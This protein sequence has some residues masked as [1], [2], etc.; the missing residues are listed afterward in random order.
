MRAESLIT[1]AW[2][3]GVAAVITL[4][5]GMWWALFADRSRGE[6]RC[7]RCWHLI[8]PGAPMQC[9]ECGR[10]F[11]SERDLLRTRRRW[12]LATAC[13]AA[14]VTGT[15]WLRVQL[16]DSG[17]WRLMPARALIALV[18]WLGDTEDGSMARGHLRMLLL[19]EALSDENAVRLLAL[20][21][22][23]DAD[24]RPG[25]E[26]WRRRYAAWLDALR[27]PRFWK[28]YGSRAA[29]REAA[30]A[31]SPVVGLVAPAVWAAGAPLVAAAEIDDWFPERLGLSLEFV[32]APGL[33]LSADALADLIGR[34]WERPEGGG[35][36]SG[37]PVTLG[38]LPAGRHAGAL[39]MRWR[40][41]ESDAPERT[42]ADGELLAPLAVE[43]LDQP[44]PL[45]PLHDEFVDARVREVF[46]PGLIRED[47]PDT[48]RFAFSYRPLETAGASLRDIAFG[49]V[50]EA[51]ERGVPRRTLHLWWCGDQSSRIGFE[52]VHEEPERLAL[53]HESPDWTLRVR[54][55]ETLARRA[56]GL[57]RSSGPLRFWSGELTL[58]LSIERSGPGRLARRWR[59]VAP[60]ARTAAPSR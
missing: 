52:I 1:L 15:L 53:A 12:L 13:L 23:G 27:G 5:Y 36:G 42:I 60:P 45:P 56:A 35:F 7:P 33:P 47:G 8:A 32:D 58:P 3:L 49:F 31:V 11:R 26:A 43:V 39:H 16:T 28:G 19:Q 10:T 22:E 9:P 6:R 34:R 44:P 14:L 55:D 21:R 46:R 48:P 2:V 25:S 51:C 17:W 4:V 24:A 29:P 40:T 30:M 57:V 38:S 41:F 50:V 59:S 18:P 20:L 37:F 54:A